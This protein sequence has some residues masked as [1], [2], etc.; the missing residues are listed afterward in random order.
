MDKK[1]RFL[2]A[3]G[4]KI[5]SDKLV[6]VP[7]IISGGGVEIIGDQDMVNMILVSRKCLND[8]YVSDQS[9]SDDAVLSISIDELLDGYMSWKLS[10]E[11]NE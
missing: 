8:E 10:Q 1:Q 5:P 3:M 4:V 9:L 2:T 11:P 7:E 6:F